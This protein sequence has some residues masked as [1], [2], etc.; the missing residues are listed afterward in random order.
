MRTFKKIARFVLE[1]TLTIC[2]IA[3]L[4]VSL[5]SSTILN[6]NYVL[7]SFEKADYYNQIYE[8]LNT[9]FENYIQQSGLDE[10]VIKDI[11]TKEKVEEDTKNILIESAIFDPVKIRF[12]SKSI[13]RSEASSRFEKGY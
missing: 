1:L 7:T 8:L 3:I 6:K 9:N 13:L 11:V 5:F 12:T 10:D 2:L 4:L